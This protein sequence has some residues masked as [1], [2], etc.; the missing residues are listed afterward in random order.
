MKEITVGTTN[1]AKLEQIRGALTPLGIRVR[2]MDPTLKAPEVVEDGTVLENSKKKAK[3]YAK[4][5]GEPV[6]SMDNAL[7]LDGLPPEQQPGTNVRRIAGR[8]DRPTDEEL[9]DHYS[10]LITGLG[11]RIKGRW[12]FA[13]C[14]ASPDGKSEE[15][16]VIESPRIFV[17][18]PCQARIPGYPLESIQVDPETGKYIAEMTTEE[19][20]IF[21]QKAIGTKLMDL[22]KKSKLIQ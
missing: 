7:Y 21:W 2:G 20:A 8:T 12:E 13:V 14:I 9:L 1:S 18:R 10:K 16:T 19:R 22:V 11:G 3:T 4:F 17:D 6:L 5:F 15:A